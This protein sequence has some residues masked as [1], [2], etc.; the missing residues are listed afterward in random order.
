MDINIAKGSKLI[1]ESNKNSNSVIPLSL[2][3]AFK[4]KVIDIIGIIHNVI[5]DSF[6]NCLL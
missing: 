1:I 2:K 4:K 5:K 3:T 6:V